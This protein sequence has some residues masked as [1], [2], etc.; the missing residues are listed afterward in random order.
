MLSTVSGRR[1]VMNRLAKLW[2]T[3]CLPR[4]IE[5]STLAVYE[6]VCAGFYVTVQVIIKVVR[7]NNCLEIL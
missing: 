6:S 2:R 3:A 7:T 4:C 1:K 5:T